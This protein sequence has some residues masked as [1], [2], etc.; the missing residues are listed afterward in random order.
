MCSVVDGCY[1]KLGEVLAESFSGFPSYLCE[2]VI[3]RRLRIP[4]I[5][6]NQEYNGGM[7]KWEFYKFGLLK[8]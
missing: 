4:Y 6:A 8:Y 5:A 7:E 2:N 1:R 3:Y